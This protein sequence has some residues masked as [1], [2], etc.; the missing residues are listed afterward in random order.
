[1][2]SFFQVPIVLVHGI[3]GFDRLGLPGSPI[4]YFRG[5]RKA[6]LGAGYTVPEPKALARGQRH[7]AG[8]RVERLPRE[9]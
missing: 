8:S 1:M 7:G 3:L 2:S 9:R 4:S 5:V 6:L